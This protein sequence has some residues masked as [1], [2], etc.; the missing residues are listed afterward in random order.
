MLC[1]IDESCVE[2]A[3][4]ILT[5][6]CFSSRPL[7]VAELVDAYAV[8]LSEPCRLDS[9]S[10][11]LDEE[12]LFEICPGLI[13]VVSS[14]NGKDD[15]GQP[16]VRIAHFSVQE[17]LVSERICRQRAAIFSIKLMESHRDIAC[18]CLVY[19]LEPGLSQANDSMKEY[20]LAF[21][22]ARHWISHYRQSGESRAISQIVLKLFKSHERFITWIRLY[23]PDLLGSA[24]PHDIPS[25][26]YYTCL[27]GLLEPAEYLLQNGV[28][29]NSFGGRHGRA[30]IAAS[31]EGHDTL[32]KVL[33]E[34]GADV[35]AQGGHYGTA[36]Q[37][38]CFW[39]YESIVFRLL[40]KGADINY[41]CGYYGFALQAASF[42]GH[43]GI[44][45]ELLR[46]GADVNAEG[47]DYGTA[48][49]AASSGG[50]LA[51]VK[52]LLDYGASV[53]IQNGRYESALQA[54]LWKEH[55]IIADLLRTNGAGL[56][57]Q[58]TSFLEWDHDY[59]FQLR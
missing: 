58:T 25:A 26:L 55:D 45:E 33:L 21:Y 32:V 38:A 59:I 23:N 39:G 37:S 44:A 52:L 35:N 28:D 8:D 41:A 10:R 16:I 34:K 4:R 24:D 7:T 20:P 27:F 46:R 49:Q 51:V 17:Y 47:G 15:I 53:D 22:A 13:E 18:I 48:L 56:K 50:H 1:R 30:L 12:S 9:E 42:R 31:W 5:L 6:L 29:I 11:R 40:E 14:R 3:R 54:A 2:D 36:L 57:S 19:L 43:R